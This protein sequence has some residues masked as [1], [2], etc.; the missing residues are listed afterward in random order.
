MQVDVCESERVEYHKA[1][2]IPWEE[3]SKSHIFLFKITSVWE[4]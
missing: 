1:Q 4:E 2:T 3:A